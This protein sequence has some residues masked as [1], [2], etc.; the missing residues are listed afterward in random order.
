MS[1][2]E[3]I[4]FYSDFIGP[5][6]G[7]QKREK[8]PR[9]AKKGGFSPPAGRVFLSQAAGNATVLFYAETGRLLINDFI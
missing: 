4:G 9:N 2:S 3:F 7:P 8:T 1:Y 6:K 5:K